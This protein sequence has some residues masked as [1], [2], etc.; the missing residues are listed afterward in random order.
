MPKIFGLSWAFEPFEDEESFFTKRMFGG[1][2]A[3]VHGKMVMVLME[4]PGDKE[5]RGKKFSFEI[6]NGILLPVERSVHQ[7]LISEF[8]ILAPHPV[9][10]KWLYLLSSETSFED[11]VQQIS[12]YIANG[13]D[14]FGILPKVK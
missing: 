12:N 9:L 5:Y 2:A 4:S 10:G 3:Y 1:M 8:S 14:R 7:S 13:D 11:V 6:W